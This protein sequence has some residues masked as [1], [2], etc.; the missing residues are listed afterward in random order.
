[1]SAAFKDHF[2]GHSADYA[3]HRPTYPRALV[4]FLAGVAPGRGLAWDVGCG[5]GQISVG[6]A[7]AFERVVATDASE[8]QLAT[9]VPHPRVTYACAPAEA[10]GLPD[11]CADLVVAAQAA[12]WF[13]LDAFYA[14][15][16]RVARPRA[17]VALVSYGVLRTDPVVAAVIEPFYRDQLG[18]YWPPERAH[19]EDGYRNLPFPFPT[20]PAPPLAI[21]VRWRLQE[22]LGYIGTWSAVKAMER[23]LGPEPMRRFA[24]EL[25]VAWGD[26]ATAREISWPLGVRAGRV[27]A[28]G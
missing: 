18:P 5:S 1:M 14:E 20:I 2:S 16:R 21:E 7:G 6:L 19:A 13:D 3:A 26:P 15:V 23:A 22:L 17:A 12:H 25:A 24:D 9:A 11:G 27:E 28:G 4:E 8:R 10:S